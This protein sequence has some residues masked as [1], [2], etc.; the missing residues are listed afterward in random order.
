MSSLRR[1]MTEEMQA[2]FDA[3]E[4]AEDWMANYRW[5]CDQLYQNIIAGKATETLYDPSSIKIPEFF[6]VMQE[7]EAKFPAPDFFTI[8]Y[9]DPVFEK[10]LM[11]DEKEFEEEEDEE[12]SDK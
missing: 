9:D 1:T 2:R 3:A 10:V 4:T 6:G 8:P 11:K 7:M 5:A 12:A